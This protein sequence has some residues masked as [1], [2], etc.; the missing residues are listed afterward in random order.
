MADMQILRETTARI[1][2]LAGHLEGLL[3]EDTG[4]DKALIKINAGALFDTGINEDD[5]YA[6]IELSLYA[7]SESGITVKVRHDYRARSLRKLE[8]RGYLKRVSG[9]ESGCVY[10][11]CGPERCLKLPPIASAVWIDRK[12]SFHDRLVYAALCCFSNTFGKSA[13]LS[14]GKIASAAKCGEG[15]AREA[16]RNLERRGLITAERRP[17]KSNAYRINESACES[18]AREE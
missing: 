1:K 14:V 11:L 2:E 12:L 15:S 16:L 13:A 8:A 5:L 18:Q 7:D 6:L 17:G 4:T 3:A 10:E 9:D